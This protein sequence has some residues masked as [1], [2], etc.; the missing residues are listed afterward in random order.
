[1]RGSLLDSAVLERGE[2][3]TGARGGGRRGGATSAGLPTCCDVSVL[4][5][6]CPCHEK[7]SK[8]KVVSWYVPEFLAC[9]DSDCSLDNAISLRAD[10][11][12]SPLC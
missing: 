1:M 10:A 2:M 11:V 5:S 12:E 4:M 9:E 6:R 3:D 7:G 8:C